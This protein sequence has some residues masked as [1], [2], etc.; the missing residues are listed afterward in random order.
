[1]DITVRTFAQ[2]RE[3]L[4]KEF[5]FSA[6]EGASIEDLLRALRINIEEGVIVLQNGRQVAAYAKLAPGDVVSI[7]P[8]IA[9][10]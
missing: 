1:M 3:R 7:F 4:D 8:M 10:G 2:F 9:G 5:V 6:T